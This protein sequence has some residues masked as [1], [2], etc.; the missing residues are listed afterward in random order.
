MP[1]NVELL[2]VSMDSPDRCV[3]E[4]NNILDAGTYGKFDVIIIDGL[5]RFEMIDIARKAMADSGAII[6]DDSAEDWMTPAEN[7][8][9]VGFMH[10]TRQGAPA[11]T[12]S[13]GLVFRRRPLP[14]LSREGGLCQKPLDSQEMM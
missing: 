9:A 11:P 10:R 6:C 4:V 7:M 5:F 2:L 3:S 12:S 8:T 14:R 13:W 1:A